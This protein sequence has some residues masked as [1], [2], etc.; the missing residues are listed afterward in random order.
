MF[1][2]KA[3]ITTTAYAQYGAFFF[4]EKLLISLIF[5]HGRNML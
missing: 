4:S 3:C 5:T 2:I 1:Q